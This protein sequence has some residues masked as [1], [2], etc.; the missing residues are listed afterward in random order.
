MKRIL[1][2]IDNIPYIIRFEPDESD[3]IID[4]EVSN[5]ELDSTI[6]SKVKA[7]NRIAELKQFLTDTDYK[8][9]KY[10]EGE[11]TASE[12]EEVKQK[13]KKAREEINSLELQLSVI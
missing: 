10:A 4:I 12:F 9:I 3:R 7:N 5:D 13:R 8:A 1:T 11:L 2:Y 6:I